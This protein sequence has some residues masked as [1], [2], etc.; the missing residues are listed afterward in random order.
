MRGDEMSGFSVHRFDEAAWRD[1][2]TEGDNSDEMLERARAAGYR[3]KPLISGD[4]SV[5]LTWVEMGPGFEVEPH[6]HDGSEVIHIL[7]GSLTPTGLA[8]P[9][10]A[11][12]S[13]VIPA[14]EIYGFRCGDEGVRFLIY[15]QVDAGIAHVDTAG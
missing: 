9:V 5:F 8:T 3:R 13:V 1:Q 7:S 6:S 11:G 2:R 4:E 10:G 15:R 14:G 12:D